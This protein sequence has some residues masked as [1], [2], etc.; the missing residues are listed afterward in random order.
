MMI[1]QDNKK[2]Y[3]KDLALLI[4]IKNFGWNFTPK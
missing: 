3:L 4:S 2:E 1:K